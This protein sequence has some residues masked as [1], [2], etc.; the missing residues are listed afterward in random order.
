M[1]EYLIHRF[2]SNLFGSGLGFQMEYERSNVAPQVIFRMGEIG[3]CGGSFTTLSSGTITS[4]SYPDNYGENANCIYTISQPTGNLIQ[5]KFLS[6]DIDKYADCEDYLEIRDGPTNASSLLD[7]LCGNEILA[8][9]MS[10]QN[11]M[12]IK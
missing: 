5:L 8:P 11:H 7:K 4:P 3:E 2:S 12:W 1:C 9:I 10:S 6:V